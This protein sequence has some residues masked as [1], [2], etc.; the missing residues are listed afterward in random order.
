VKVPLSVKLPASVKPDVDDACRM[1]RV[2][3]L[4]EPLTSRMRSLVSLLNVVVVP[5]TSAGSPMV[6]TPPTL[7][8]V[9]V[10]PP[11]TVTVTGVAEDKT[12]K[13]GIRPDLPLSASTT[14]P[15]AP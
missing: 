2:V 11:L 6:R 1:P 7:I 9:P 13:R 4:T 10:P 15:V 8:V 3:M 12:H 5:A 14:P